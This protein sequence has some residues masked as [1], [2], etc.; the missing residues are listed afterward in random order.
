[1]ATESLLRSSCRG[2][3]CALSGGPS[4]EGRKHRLQLGEVGHDG[5]QV[6]SRRGCGERREE[7]PNVCKQGAGGLWVKQMLAASRPE[8]TLMP[9]AWPLTPEPWGQHILSVSPGVPVS[10]GG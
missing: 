2:E 10:S 6:T 1:M 5:G 8:R 9:G 7:P 4:S 3:A